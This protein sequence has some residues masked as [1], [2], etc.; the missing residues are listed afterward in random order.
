MQGG[1]NMYKTFS[2]MNELLRT[3]A[4]INPKSCGGQSIENIANF[5]NISTAMLYKWRSGQSNLAFDKLDNLLLY[6]ENNE[7]I[8]LEMAERMMGW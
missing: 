2:E 8:R 6:F 5:T 3:T 4:N 1:D 7:P